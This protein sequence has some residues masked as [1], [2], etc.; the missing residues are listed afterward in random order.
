MNTNGGGYYEVKGSE[1]KVEEDGEGEEEGER[2]D[3]DDN[4]VEDVYN[5]HKV[6]FKEGKP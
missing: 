5:K 6:V 2:N 1:E 3:D 4:N